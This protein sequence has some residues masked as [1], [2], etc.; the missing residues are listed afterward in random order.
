MSTSHK[1]WSLVAAMFAAVIISG[2]SSSTSVSSNDG[3]V[4]MQSQ[5]ATSDVDQAMPIK[6]ATPQNVDFDSI[7][8]TNAIV[9]V[10]DV[11]LHSDMDDTDIDTHDEEIKTGPFVIVFD[12]SGV[13]TVT[14]TTIPAGTYD[15]IKFEFHKPNK[16]ADTAILAQFPELQN[17]GQ[18]YTVWIFGYTY[19]AGVR[20]AFSVT[21]THS[22]NITL[23]FEDK[24][25]NDRDNIVLNSNQTMTLAFELDP[26]ILF[27]LRGLI[28]G[29][30][31]DPRDLVNHQSDIDSNVLFA[32]RVVEF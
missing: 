1:S 24:D 16:N 4:T 12:S 10:S 11:K 23:R 28:S 6:V 8:I 5:L 29:G 2:C 26:R 31:F 3:T 25:F 22:E 18:T 7:V 32:I 14:T 19:K 15:R 21:S 20:T 13:H 27:H 9:F 30:L 17:G